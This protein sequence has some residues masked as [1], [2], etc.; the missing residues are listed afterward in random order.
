M[1]AAAAAAAAGGGG[2]G[3][4]AAAAWCGGGG[5]GGG[6]GPHAAFN[7][8]QGGRYSM[9]FACQVAVSGVQRATRIEHESSSKNK[10]A[11]TVEIEI[12]GY[13]LPVEFY[14][15]RLH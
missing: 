5:G 12:P 1:G 6:G 13:K 3:G 10:R 8:Q 15:A 11:S 7:A 2:G 9:H 14:K 4:G